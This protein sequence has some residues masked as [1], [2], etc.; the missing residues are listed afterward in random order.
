M[1]VHNAVSSFYTG[2]MNSK[3]QQWLENLVSRIPSLF[4]S[5]AQGN[6]KSQ[7]VIG[8]RTVNGRQVKLYLVAEVVDAGP[9]P[10]ENHASVNFPDTGTPPERPRT[11]HS[12]RGR[13]KRW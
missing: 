3:Q 13:P 11:Q 1:Y 8:E 2:R 4:D 12:R 10:L 6:Q 7:Y 5:I 9:D